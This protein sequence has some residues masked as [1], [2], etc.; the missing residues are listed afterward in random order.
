MKIRTKI[1]PIDWKIITIIS[2][3]FLFITLL[4]SN[5]LVFAREAESGGGSNSGENA[6]FTIT[7]RPDDNPSASDLI[8]G[9]RVFVPENSG[10]IS[11]FDSARD[12]QERGL[13]S[14]FDSARDILER[15]LFSNNLGFGMRHDDVAELQRHLQDDRFFNG[16]V[17][18][19]FG[20]ITREA[21]REFQLAHGIP[22]TG[23]V[24]PLTRAELNR[25]RG[26]VS[27]GSSNSGSSNSG[28]SETEM[29]QKI[30]EMQA[31]I[32]TLMQMLENRIRTQNF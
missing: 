20:E 24:G 2:A 15:E 25:G 11:G 27:S 21:V 4:S 26:S 10:G 30:A 8:E 31:Q 18:G 19:F 5:I 12:I 14:G 16:P 9:T 29:R 13:L 6:G 1:L 3:V 7:P 22:T 23:F 32:G 28:M 17:T